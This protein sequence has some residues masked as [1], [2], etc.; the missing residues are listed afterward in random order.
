MF[1][2]LVSIDIGKQAHARIGDWLKRA[3]IEL[4]GCQLHSF[5]DTR[6]ELVGERSIAHPGKLSDHGH[7]LCTRIEIGGDGDGVP[8]HSAWHSG[9]VNTSLNW[10]IMDPP[11]NAILN[12]VSALPCVDHVHAIVIQPAG[13]P[14]SAVHGPID[15]LA[16]DEIA[17]TPATP[18]PASA[19]INWQW[20]IAQHTRCWLIALT[21]DLREETHI[22][23]LVDSLRLSKR[24]LLLPPKFRF[25]STAALSEFFRDLGRTELSFPETVV[26]PQQFACNGRRLQS[27]IATHDVNQVFEA[28]NCSLG[29][30]RGLQDRCIIQKE[31]GAAVGL[32]GDVMT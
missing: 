21:I 27:W 7:D 28:L 11:T 29:V 14:F 31:V 30:L 20:V 22:E 23:R 12:F 6:I 9:S 17:A 5:D 1:Y 19:T 18:W 13:D 3:I 26:F 32:L 10:R 2:M 24:V 15:S 25:D 4:P 16:L 8:Y